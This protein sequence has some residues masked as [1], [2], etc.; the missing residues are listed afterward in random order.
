MEPEILLH[1]NTV[2][3]NQR[4]LGSLLSKLFYGRV[5]QTR[6]VGK[7]A[8]TVEDD[9]LLTMMGLETVY[10]ITRDEELASFRAMDLQALQLHLSD[11]ETYT[12]FT[13]LVK[14]SIYSSDYL[15]VH[16]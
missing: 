13:K 6:G 16:L 1:H 5:R 11:T 12:A 9:I 2:T 4:L 10:V 8:K 3:V 15:T 14:D 7:V